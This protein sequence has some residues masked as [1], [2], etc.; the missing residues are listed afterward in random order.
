[1]ATA[2]IFLICVPTKNTAFTLREKIFKYY[3]A[4]QSVR[5]F[6]NYFV[7]QIS[8]QYLY[9]YILSLYNGSPFIIRFP[10]L[11]LGS[12][13][14]C[15][16]LI[17]CR[18]RSRYCC[19]IANISLAGWNVTSVVLGMNRKLGDNQNIILHSHENVSKC[20][21]INAWQWGFWQNS[22]YISVVFFL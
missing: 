18:V 10:L 21:L 19:A 2:V 13:G 16:L 22:T 3:K 4:S 7:G 20:F 9:Q 14:P 1:M 6:T 15:L 8:S 12:L 11:A 5:T 17:M